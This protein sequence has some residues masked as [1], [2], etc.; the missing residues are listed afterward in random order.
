MWLTRV[1]A[2]LSWQLD[3]GYNLFDELNENCL[4]LRNYN[5]DK[6][7]DWGGADGYSDY[8]RLMINMP[9]I[10]TICR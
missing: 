9:S 1:P 6:D 10:I 3:G 5:S 4:Y 8:L 2:S 7:L